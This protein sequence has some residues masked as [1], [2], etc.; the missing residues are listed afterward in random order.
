MKKL[1][2]ST[3]LATLITPLFAED[4]ICAQVITPAKS[5]ESGECIE[6]PTPCD[7]PEGWEVVASC[8]SLPNL[9]EDE[10]VVKVKSDWDLLGAM[11]N[12]NDMSI[13]DVNCIEQIWIYNY[14]RR[15][16]SKYDKKPYMSD[17]PTIE[18]IKAGRGFW[19]KGNSECDI[20]ITTNSV[21]L[22]EID[23][24]GKT[25]TYDSTEKGTF[26]ET[27]YANGSM[28]SSLLKDINMS[29]SIVDGA[30]QGK[31]EETFTAIPPFNFLDKPVVGTKV[32][33]DFYGN[34]TISNISDDIF[35]KET[36]EILLNN[37]EFYIKLDSNPTTGYSWRVINYDE[38]IFKTPISS[39][40]TLENDNL[41]GAGGFD[42]FFFNLKDEV[43]AESS[44]VEL[45]YAQHWD[46]GLSAEKVEFVIYFP[47]NSYDINF[48]ETIK[49][50]DGKLIVKFEY[51]VDSRCATGAQCITA[52]D[53]NVTLGI[54]GMLEIYETS[55]FKL[56]ET[57]TNAQGYSITLKD[58]K[59]YPSLESEIDKKDYTITIEIQ[60]PE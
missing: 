37:K 28:K 46:G 31:S 18:Q 26:S 52:G 47:T 12:I 50:D 48:D 60:R 45:E 16:W 39:Y 54:T 27:Y 36:K 1:F 43:L 44:I 41:V 53:V 34:L 4:V 56:N 19:I 7:V 11:K 51:I 40:L 58:V 49:I 17:Y 24:A 5:I 32:E 13:F 22:N 30:L 8:D 42:Y 25:I 9:I 35:T 23:I 10:S 33:A 38:N 29:W 21:E 57:K 15:M 3:I 20:K 59:P 14:D 55:S 2:I 6:Y